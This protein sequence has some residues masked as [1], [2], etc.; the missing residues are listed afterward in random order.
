MNLARSA[1]MKRTPRRSSALPAVRASRAAGVVAG[2][3][4]LLFL[5][6]ALAENTAC[7]RG[8][9]DVSFYATFDDCLAAVSSA[10]ESNPQKV[11][12]Q[13]RFV[14]GILGKA[15]V[16]GEAGKALAYAVKGNL[17][18]QKGSISFWLKHHGHR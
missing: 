15:V 8:I 12:G 7:G 17:D 11:V 13:Y 5:S 14:P 2:A 9:K 16:A 1:T 6:P 4:M 18:T 10:G 3:A